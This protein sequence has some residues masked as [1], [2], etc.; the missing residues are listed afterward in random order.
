[1]ATSLT[2]KQLVSDDITSGSSFVVNKGADGSTA[3]AYAI[4]N[5]PS[6]L[7]DI[8][9]FYPSISS[10]TVGG[11]NLFTEKINIAF[12]PCRW[13]STQ[14]KFF[15]GY[16][17]GDSKSVTI[18]ESSGTTSA[19]CTCSKDSY[20]G[21]FGGDSLWY[22]AYKIT[23]SSANSSIGCKV[24][25]SGFALSVDTRDVA[26]Y[27][28]TTAASPAEGGT[29]TGGGTYSDS[30]SATLTATPNA[31]WYL[32]YWQKD[33]VVVDE[34]YVDTNP[35]TV[36]VTGNAT[37][38][39]VFEKLS[40]S[41]RYNSNGGTGTMA[42]SIAQYQENVTLISNQ[43]TRAGY[44]FGGWATSAAGSKVYDDEATF[45]YPYTESKDLYAVWAPNN[46]YI[47][48]QQPLKIYFDTKKV[49]AVYID[50]TKVYG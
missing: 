47:G 38:T 50:T 44:S 14:N 1:M 30:N 23:V 10:V 43:F 4:F 12:D 33:G 3:T 39:A 21:H 2:F 22:P 34:D 18:S 37:Y 24:V 28:I 19:S 27:T 41:I 8:S 35:Y 5:P 9:N 7:C 45:Q 15:E 31:G 29:V 17:D 11:N 40:Y 16:N 26:F 46:I 20:V 48:T 42:L 13:H 36:S 25:L 6:K 49:K 32:A